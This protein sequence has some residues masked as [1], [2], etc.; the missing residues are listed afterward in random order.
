MII[1]R[2]SWQGSLL[3]ISEAFTA[4]VAE[5]VVALSRGCDPGVA[6]NA[7]RIYGELQGEEARFRRTLAAGE[8]FLRGV[9]QVPLALSPAR[10]SARLL[11]SSVQILG[12][13]PFPHLLVSVQGE[14]VKAREGSGAV[15]R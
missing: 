15:D 7:P 3:G 1:V 6:A 9:L 5:V 13:D 8:K 11:L 14:A 2:A 10:P 4:R 12:E